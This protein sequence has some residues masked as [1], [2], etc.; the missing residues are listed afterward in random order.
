Q[1]WPDCIPAAI[2]GDQ[3]WLLF[4]RGIGWL[5]WRH[6]DSR[7]SLGRAFTAFR[8]H[9][10]TVGMFLAWAGVIFALMSEGELVPMDRWIALLDEIMHDAPQ[11]PSKGVETRVATAMLIALV[12][13]QPHHPQAR[14]LVQRAIE[15][16]QGDLS[17]A[18]GVVD[19]MRALL[20]TRDVSPV[21]A[22]NASMT[23]AWYEALT[24]VPSYRDTVTQ[25]L[26]REQATGIFYSA[27]H[28]VLSAG[29]IA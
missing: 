21:M 19:E 4:W 5:G 14:G 9:G 17:N 16:A 3:P 11:F 22:V 29:L 25:V 20:R 13:R 1:G 10:D 28:V 27:R 23:V 8:I 26:E 24:A 2:L 7:C 18:T 12:C 6:A 15:L